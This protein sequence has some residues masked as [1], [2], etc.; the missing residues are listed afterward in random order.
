MRAEDRWL[1]PGEL[2]RRLLA[3]F[4][5]EGIELAQRGRV[6]MMPPAAPAAAAAG[7]EGPAP[8][9]GDEPDPGGPA[10]DPGPDDL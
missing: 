9:S 7:A 5:A 3:A 1:A 8:L 4:S 6:V 2:N 10:E